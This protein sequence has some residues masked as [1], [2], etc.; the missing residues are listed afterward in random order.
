MKAATAYS[1]EKGTVFPNVTRGLDSMTV[2]FTPHDER[3]N[4]LEHRY[5]AFCLA[6]ALPMG[7]LQE[8]KGGDP[9]IPT[10]IPKE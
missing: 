1:P 10:P 9:G 8:F 2:K 4:T 6:C 7:T 3:S 5:S